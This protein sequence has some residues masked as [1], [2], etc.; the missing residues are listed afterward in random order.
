MALSSAFR[1]SRRW[2][3]SF[4]P[5]AA[6]AP[7][8]D[9]GR[10][11]VVGSESGEMGS[12]RCWVVVAPWLLR[13]GRRGFRT[14]RPSRALW[15][16]RLG[17]VWHC[18]FA[19]SPASSGG[20]VGFPLREPLTPAEARPPLGSVSRAALWQP[21]PASAFGVTSPDVAAVLALAGEFRPERLEFVVTERALEAACSSVGVCR[22]DVHAWL[23]AN[24]GRAS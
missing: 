1:L 24:S 15:L 5:Q 9:R 14:E 3:V 10:C 20:P 6:G 16:A 12:A 22:S 11:E 13:W 19:P 4:G 8:V 17:P 18:R 7:L 21:G 23:R 2:F